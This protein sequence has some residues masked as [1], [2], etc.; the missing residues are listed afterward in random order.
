[1]SGRVEGAAGASGRVGQARAQ[2]GMAPGY[3]EDD[4][5]GALAAGLG[6]DHGFGQDRVGRGR[7]RVG[8]GDDEPPL[9]VIQPLEMGRDDLAAGGP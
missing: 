6:G 5:A 1:M 4:V 3:Q 9:L 7:A 8:Q 2:T